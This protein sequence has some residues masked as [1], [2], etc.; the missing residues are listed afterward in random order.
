MGLFDGVPA[1]PAAPAP[2]PTSPRCSACRCCW[3]SMSAARRNR[4]RRV[5]KGCATYDPRIRDRRRRA[6]PGRQRAARRLAGE[7]IEALG[8]PV[9]GALPRD[10]RI[11]LPERHLGLVQAGETADLDARLDALADFVATPRRSRRASPAL[12]APLAAAPAERGGAAAAGPAHRDRARRGLLVPLSACARGLARRR[13]RDRCSSRRSPTS[14]RPATPM[15]AGCPAAIP[16]CTP[17]ALAAARASSPAC[18]VSP[19]RG[20]CT[21]SAAATWRS[22]AAL[23]DAAGA[24]PCDG[25]P[26]V[27]RDQLRQAHA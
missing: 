2:R 4:R 15:P 5:V 8:I 17:A 9:L 13:R 10:E 1:P 23:T 19:R 25:G 7:A 22:G 26:A 21:A 12:A 6:Q 11:A 27:G 20:P 3:C 18:G 16:N 24:S 14:R